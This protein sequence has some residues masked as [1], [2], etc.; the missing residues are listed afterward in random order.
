MYIRRENNYLIIIVNKQPNKQHHLYQHVSLNHCCQCPQIVFKQFRFFDKTVNCKELYS[1][2][3]A[4]YMLCLMSHSRWIC[5]DFS[6][7]IFLM[8][9]IALEH[10]R[11]HS[12]RYGTNEATYIAT[13]TAPHF[14]FRI[15]CAHGG[16]LNLSWFESSGI[17]T[18][19]ACS[20]FICYVSPE[21]TQ[22]V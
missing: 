18:R 17:K 12:S 21:L 19:H 14:S 15:T 11:Q 20:D 3:N 7:A 13:L 8:S 6:M 9:L 5:L 1:T 2:P 10:N 4:S 22:C 16:S